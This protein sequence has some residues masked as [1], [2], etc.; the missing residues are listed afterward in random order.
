MSGRRIKAAEAVAPFP[1]E[2]RQLSPAEMIEAMGGETSMIVG[3]L[4]VPDG[5]DQDAPTET[6][7][8]ELTSEERKLFSSLLTCGQ[9][10]KTL[11]IMGHTV[12]IRT[13]NAEDD[14]RIGLY[15]KD[16]VGSAAEQ[17]AY[18]I[19]VAACGIV[20]ING[21]PVYQSLTSK[22]DGTEVFDAKV[23]KIVSMTS[24]VVAQIYRAVLGLESEFVELA[25][26]LG[27]LSG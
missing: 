19:G 15:A 16:Y 5:E 14:L 20:A 7:I 3:E 12:T 10:R 9:R 21:T 1:D 22:E 17:R 8:T 4:T 24:L 26:R 18:Q 6:E 11:D 13:L 23:K 27:K 2:D 25:Q